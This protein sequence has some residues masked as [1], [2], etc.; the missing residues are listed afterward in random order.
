MNLFDM[1]GSGPMGA[2]GAGGVD[3]AMLTDWMHAHQS[4]RA[5][6]QTAE[7]AN[8]AVLGAAPTG[9]PIP[10]MAQPSAPVGSPAALA[11]FDPAIVRALLAAHARQQAMQSQQ[12]PAGGSS[13]PFFPMHGPAGY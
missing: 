1:I 10:S 11:G 4:K 7:L 6:A 5:T 12:Q 3:P 8:R 2:S 13:P 9:S